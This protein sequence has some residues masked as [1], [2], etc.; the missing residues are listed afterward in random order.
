MKLRLVITYEGE[1]ADESEHYIKTIE[2]HKVVR[3]KYN[4]IIRLK[5]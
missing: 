2:L 4:K 3:D 1:I 5:A